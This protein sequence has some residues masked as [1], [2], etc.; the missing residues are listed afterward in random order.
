M[1]LCSYTA[2]ESRSSTQRTLG[3][4]QSRLAPILGRPITNNANLTTVRVGAHGHN[5]KTAIGVKYDG[6]RQ[7]HNSI[8]DW[9]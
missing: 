7:L 9:L 3:L 5:I 4:K 2:Q 8:L 1:P 6:T